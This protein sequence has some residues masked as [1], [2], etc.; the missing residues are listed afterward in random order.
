MGFKAIPRL[1]EHAPR[2]RAT[3][4]SLVL[5]FCSITLS[6]ALLVLLRLVKSKDAIILFFSAAQRNA[7]IIFLALEGEGHARDF[8]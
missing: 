5:L 8:D 6:R 4:H 2:D 3:Y 7:V 1:R